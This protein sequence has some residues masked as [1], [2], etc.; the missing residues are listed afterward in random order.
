[1]QGAL[2]LGIQT[3][4]GVVQLHYRVNLV[5]LTTSYIVADGLDDDS[6]EAEAN[7]LDAL[8][9][10]A[11]DILANNFME[12]LFPNAPPAGPLEP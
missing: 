10:P 9:A 1:M 2:R 11:A 4:L 12:I 8:A 3:T 5:A 6:A 7:R